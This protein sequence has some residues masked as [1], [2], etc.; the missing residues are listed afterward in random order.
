MINNGYNEPSLEHPKDYNKTNTFIKVVNVV[1]I[2]TTNPYTYHVHMIK[3]Y[4]NKQIEKSYILSPVVISSQ[5]TPPLST[6]FYR[7]VDPPSPNKLQSFS[8]IL[9]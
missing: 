9:H 2:T 5:T 8:L 3:M 1:S 4:D 7:R 6:N